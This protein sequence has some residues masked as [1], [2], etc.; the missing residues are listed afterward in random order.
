MQA[1]RLEDQIDE[2]SNP[3]LHFTYR[4]RELERELQSMETQVQ[5]TDVNGVEARKLKKQVLKRFELTWNKMRSKVHPDEMICGQCP[6][7][8]KIIDIFFA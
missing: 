6:F 2:Y 1:E 4:F 8:G 7:P 3:D 5:L